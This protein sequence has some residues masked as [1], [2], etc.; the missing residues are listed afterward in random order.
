MT[1]LRAGRK[2][3]ALI[4]AKIMGLAVVDHDW[5]CG[6]EPS[7]G[8]YEAGLTKEV[9]E[10]GCASWYKERGPVYVEHP[11]NWPPDPE[12]DKYAW[13][14]PVP[15]Y[16]TDI[17]ASWQVVTEIHRRIDSSDAGLPADANYLTLN[18]LG[19]GD[20]CS[21]IFSSVVDWDWYEDLEGEYP[22]GAEGESPAHAIC[23]AALK[24]C[25]VEV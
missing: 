18:S 21:A 14:V 19:R 20:A 10:D 13:P 17:A 24:I 15:F 23:L 5:P 6:Y 7:C 9:G 16:S 4:G 25:G 1:E 22:L 2:L 3:D 8:C 12:H 11:E